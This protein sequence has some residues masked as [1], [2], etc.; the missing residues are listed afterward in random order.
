MPAERDNTPPK[1]IDEDA[2]GVIVGGPEA[3]SREKEGDDPA[4]KREP[5]GKMSPPTRDTSR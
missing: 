2:P 3:H 4:N 5:V 1:P